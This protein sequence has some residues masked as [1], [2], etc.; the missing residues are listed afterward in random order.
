MSRPHPDEP[1][2][3]Q[4]STRAAG[5]RQVRHTRRT[6]TAGHQPTNSSPTPSFPPAPVAS[7]T[8]GP[9]VPLPLPLSPAGPEFLEVL[10]TFRHEVFTP[11]TVIEG[12]T[13]T[14]LSHR[15]Q[16]ESEEQ[17][18]FLQAIRHAGRRLERLTTQLLDLAQLEAGMLGL[19]WSPVDLAALARKTVT[20]A[21]HQVP[22]PLRDRLVFVVRCRDTL[23]EPTSNPIV[24]TGDERRL[25]Q[26]IEHLLENA[27]AFSPTG[28]RIDVI[29]RPVPQPPQASGGGTTG[30]AGSAED[31]AFVELCVCDVGVGIPEGD[32]ERVFAPFYRVDT[33]LTREHDGLGLGLTLCKHLV[34]LHHGRLWVES[35]PAGGSAFHVWLPP[36]GPQAA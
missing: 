19:T 3:E 8:T 18:Q 6:G 23:G 32:L 24:V 11:L 25:R 29:I 17:D 36:D 9:L 16:L 15:E 10:D 5:K 1:P 14:L 7:P 27:I 21:E 4:A 33:R 26:V 13:S 30:G 20:Q 12:Y 2:Q 35:C 28:G 34:T 22:D 31:T